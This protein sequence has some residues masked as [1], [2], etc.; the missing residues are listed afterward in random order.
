MKKYI[1]LIFLI[2]IT[3]CKSENV[4]KCEI[5][6]SIDYGNNK[7]IIEIYGEDNVSKIVVKDNFEIKNEFSEFSETIFS[8]I[9]DTY[10]NFINNKYGFNL[11][12]EKN[13]LKFDIE[14]I[15]DVNSLEEEIKNGMFESILI[16]DLKDKLI[17]DGYTCN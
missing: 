11:N 5:S 12:K 1:I 15:I 9:Y 3:G 4:T 10:E 17:R 8:S 7:K 13:N 16:N 6:N 2:I 14:L